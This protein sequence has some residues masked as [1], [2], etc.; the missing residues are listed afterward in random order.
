MSPRI[1]DR[2]TGQ[3]LAQ[4]RAVLGDSAV[5]TDACDLARYQLS[6]SEFEPRPL[7][8]VLH[9]SSVDDVQRIVAVARAAH[10]PIHPIST[11]RSWGLG[12]ALPVRGP[13]A[14]VHL[15]RMRQILAV[16]ERFHHAVIEP[17]VTQGQL[18]AHLAASGETLKLNVTGAGPDTSI[19]GNI[20]DRGDGVLGSR[21]D[22]LLGLE[23]V[24]GTGDVVRTG[25]CHLG[26][27]REVAPSPPRR[28][29][30]D[31]RGLFL[32]SAF[33]IVTK[34]AVRLHPRLP[35]LEL[36]LEAAPEHLSRL[37]DELRLALV[38]GLVTGALRIGDGEDS[39]I[40]SLPRTE[41]PEWKAQLIIRGTRPMRTE[42]SRELQQR[43][44]ALTT[45]IQAFDT[46]NDARGT[47]TGEDS[48]L[49]EARLRL[50]DGTPSNRSLERLAS[51][52]GKSLTDVDLDGDR[53]IPGFLCANVSVPF[54]GEHVAACAATVQAVA[55][56]AGTAISRSFALLDPTTL[57]GFFPFYF[58]RRQVDTVAHAHAVKDEL[59]Q[60]LEAAGMTAMRLDIDSIARL[61]ERADDGHWS[62][63]NAI[64]RALDPDGIISPGRYCGVSAHD[65]P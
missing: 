49:L 25:L 8:A 63:V 28:L 14:L 54:S 21:S 29:G 65:L 43:L 5:S 45:R 22:E 18:A 13:A 60:R 46:E 16:D 23:V 36:M 15:G 9:P 35:F 56:E 37:V 26:M 51:L 24:L 64:K 61:A 42:A 27:R 41:T 10:V 30:P 12:S 50:A 52:A 4:W 32:Q 20:L 55:D 58:D 2:A 3:A 33:G 53:D 40:R 6:I 38:D 44:A 19:I 31:L 17:G 11:G 39:I 62:T 47:R 1:P 59:L 48:T 7:L 34:M 57:T